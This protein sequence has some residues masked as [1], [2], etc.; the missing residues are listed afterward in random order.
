MNNTTQS[1]NDFPPEIR[2]LWEKINTAETKEEKSALF[3]ELLQIQ[4]ELDNKTSTVEKLYSDNKVYM[5]G[6]RGWILRNIFHVNL[7]TEKPIKKFALCES[8]RL[9]RKPGCEEHQAIQSISDL[10]TK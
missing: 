7:Q 3:S 4:S 1:V 5:A 8:Y 10:E 6:L 9:I 2:A